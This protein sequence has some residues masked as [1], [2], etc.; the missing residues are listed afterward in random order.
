MI[1]VDGALTPP[2]LQSSFEAKDLFVTDIDK[3][4]APRRHPFLDDLAADVT[5]ITRSL[6]LAETA[7]HA[8]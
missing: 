3:T 6:C 1:R 5:L 8:S 2:R 4:T 7:W